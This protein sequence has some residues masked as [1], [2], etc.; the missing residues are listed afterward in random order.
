MDEPAPVGFEL[1]HGM[2]AC[3]VEAVRLGSLRF[4]T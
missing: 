3:Q 1:L 4:E 2:R